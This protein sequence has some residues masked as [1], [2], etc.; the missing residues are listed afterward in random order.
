MIKE[1]ANIIKGVF[2]HKKHRKS[3]FK[4]ISWFHEKLIKHQEDKNVKKIK[5][6]DFSIVYKRPYEL[7]H[8]YKEIFEK[9]IYCFTS[10]TQTP[11]IIDCG[12]NIGLS[13]LYFKKLYPNAKVIAFEPDHNNFHLLQMNIQNN[14]LADIELN[15][16]AVWVTNGELTFEA[17]ESE[18]SH[19]SDKAFGH[20]VKSVRLNDVLISYSNIDFLKIDIEGAEFEVLKDISPS[21]HRVKN[22]F[23]EYHGTVEQTSKL[24]EALGLLSHGGFNVYI[25]NAADNLEIPFIDKRTGSTYDVQL[26]LFCYK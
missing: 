1:T 15:Q 16:S 9:E 8:S 18:A 12:S 3:N 7:L 13:V 6:P 14:N 21:L 11:L 25:R 23:L 20:K 5:F 24:S 10:S 26:N 22:L 4:T 17:K 19:I 2:K